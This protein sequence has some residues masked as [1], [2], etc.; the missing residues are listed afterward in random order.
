VVRAIGSRTDLTYPEQFEEAILEMVQSISPQEKGLLQRLK[1]SVD[2]EQPALL[3]SAIHSLGQI[4]GPNSEALLTK[5]VK[6]RS[7]QAAGAKEALE[8]IRARSM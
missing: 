6:S 4:G 1:K 8:S 7:A 3:S 2:S 5:L